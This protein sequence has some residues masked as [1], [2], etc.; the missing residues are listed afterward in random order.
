[1][2]GISFRSLSKIAYTFLMPGTNYLYDFLRGKENI[3]KR[4]EGRF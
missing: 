1:M 4:P 2:G 3:K